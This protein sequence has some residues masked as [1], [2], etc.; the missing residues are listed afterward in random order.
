MPGYACKISAKINISSIVKQNI[1]SVISR[2]NSQDL[3]PTGTK[4]ANG[5]CYYITGL[6]HQLYLEFTRPIR[7]I[8]P[9]SVTFSPNQEI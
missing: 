6:L 4:H 9:N 8:G 3:Q 1:I 7:Y 2:H 5:S